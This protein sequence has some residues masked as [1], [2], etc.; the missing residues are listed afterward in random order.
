MLSE[1]RPFSSKEI[2]ENIDTSVRTV[3]NY[4]NEI[5]GLSEEKII[6][7]SENRY[8]LNKTAARSL[9]E[10][11]TEILEFLNMFFN[12][13]TKLKFFHGR[14]FGENEQYFSTMAGTATVMEWIFF[15][16]KGCKLEVSSERKRFGFLLVKN[17]IRFR[18]RPCS[19]KSAIKVFVAPTSIAICIVLF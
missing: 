11:K 12:S 4:I 8:W 17:F 7:N 19:E 1:D 2:S 9:L 6:F 5:N 13:G 18:Q 15:F 3:T 10:E 16:W 14:F